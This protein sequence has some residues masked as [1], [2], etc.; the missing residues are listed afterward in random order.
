M[1]QVQTAHVSEKKR[2]EVELLKEI[3]RKNEVIAVIDL[4]NLSADQFLKIKHKIR[5]KAY[6]RVTKKRL[7]KIVFNELKNEK[8]DLNKLNDMLKGI[9]ALLFTSEDE[10][11]LQKLLN[12]NKSNT[13]AKSGQAAN[14][15][16]YIKAGPTQFTPGPM[17][18]EFG[19]LGIKTQV[20][21]GKIHI[22]ED[23][24]LVKEGDIINDKTAS[25]LSKLGIQPIEVG[26]NLLFTYRKGDILTKDILNI[27]E[28]QYL[29]DLKKA[30]SEALNLAVG[31]VYTSKETIDVLI[32]KAYLNALALENKTGNLS[33]VKT[34]EKSP[35]KSETVKI[36]EE[37]QEK[38]ETPLNEEI[39]HVR[40]TKKEDF[41]VEIKKVDATQDQ[42]KS[43]A[44][45]LRQ[46]T[47]K[48]IRGEI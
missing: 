29:E 12:K 42:M 1:M 48:K 35:E 16:I 23:K 36:K 19:Q 11:K 39:K 37:N 14:K 30:F 24:L 46:L 8:K 41:K 32:R 7:M 28:Q 20:T 43:A 26:L 18:G 13:F 27:N 15:D 40:E 21:E 38:K 6:I 4:Q 10:F 17:I 3:I 25:V 9:P 5:E 33:N 2:K 44:D 22:K 34:E 31:S 45:I 47:D